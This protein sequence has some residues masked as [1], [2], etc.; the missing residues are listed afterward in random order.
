MYDLTVCSVRL[1]DASVVRDV[2]P[3]RVDP[4]EGEVLLWE[5]RVVPVLPDDALG[6]VQELVHGRLVPPVLQVAC[7][8][9]R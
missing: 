2:L 1:F 3:L 4:V 6:L 9:T 7:S 5:S 8:V